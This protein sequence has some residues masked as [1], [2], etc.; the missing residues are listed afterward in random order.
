M[1]TDLLNL[2]TLLCKAIAAAPGARSGSGIEILPDIICSDE[3]LSAFERITIYADAYFYRLF[4]CLKEDFPA[5]AA[6]VGEA[7]FQELVRLYLTQFP[8]TEPSIFYAG[9][10]LADFLEGHQLGE[11][12]PFLAE[13]ARL[14]RTILE[15]FHERDATA[16]DASHLGN[17]TPADWPMLRLRTH[18]TLRILDCEWRVND[19]RRAVENET[20]WIEP[21]RGALA[22]LVWRQDAQVYYRELEVA[23]RAALEASSTGADLAAIC[24]V[25]A[26]HLDDQDP[27][28]TINRVLTGWIVDGLFV[29]I[30]NS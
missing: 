3:R 30:E 28:A 20:Q 27:A 13:L 16:L 18:P 7:E 6:V 25:L 14:E 9:R 21:A 11:R 1:T 2:Q 15:V 4:D 23:E 26:S 29:A 12:R 22:V 19:V 8:P 10:Y 24:E 17:I 5:T